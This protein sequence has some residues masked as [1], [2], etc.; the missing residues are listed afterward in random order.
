MQGLL[1][2]KDVDA[3]RLLRE[4][5]DDEDDEERPAIEKPLTKAVVSR[6]LHQALA[7]L[8]VARGMD[9]S[10]NELLKRA[11]EFVEFEGWASP[12]LLQRR[13]RVN[14]HVAV[15][16]IATLEDEGR[17]RK[18]GPRWLPAEGD[19]LAMSMQR[20]IKSNGGDARPHAE[21]SVCVECHQEYEPTGAHQKRCPTCASVRRLQLGWHRVC[22]CRGCGREYERGNRS[23]RYCPE[24]REERQRALPS[25]T[26][27]YTESAH[28]CTDCGQEYEPTGRNQ[29][30]CTACRRAHHAREVAL[31]RRRRLEAVAQ[32]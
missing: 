8:D 25:L 29:R 11:A 4:A 22:K 17:L 1:T 15:A 30:R 21:A 16:L 6:V 2:T 20:G 24:C 13:L 31:S 28:V 27:V 18:E 32:N 19:M 23:E 26:K 10:V 9:A 12:G 3:D 7:W 5:L 14:Q